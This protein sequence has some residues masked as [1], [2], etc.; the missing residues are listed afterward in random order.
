MAPETSQVKESNRNSSSI[1]YDSTKNSKSSD[2]IGRNLRE[3][4]VK[5]DV[6]STDRGGS[7]KSHRMTVALKL[8]H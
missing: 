4:G 3:C 7:V 8:V 2:S 6:M 1:N 5:C